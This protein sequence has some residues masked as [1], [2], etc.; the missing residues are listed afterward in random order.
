MFIFRK[1]Q[2]LFRNSIKLA[3]NDINRKKGAN[4][5]VKTEEKK[6]VIEEKKDVEV[7]DTTVK[8]KKQVKNNLNV[9]EN[10]NVVNN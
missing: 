8:V 2:N 6:E 4:I 3:V 5:V 1:S 7:V 9:E 10:N